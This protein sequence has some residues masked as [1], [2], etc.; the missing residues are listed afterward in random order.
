MTCSSISNCFSVQSATAVGSSSV[1]EIFKRLLQFDQEF[2]NEFLL[3]SAC[4]IHVTILSHF[5][6]STVSLF[7]AASEKLVGL[8]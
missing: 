8:F 3:R 7:A 6:E 5:V 2:S 4:T 1:V